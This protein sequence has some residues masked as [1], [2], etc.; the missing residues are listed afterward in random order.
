[1]KNVKLQCIYYSVFLLSVVLLYMIYTRRLNLYDNNNNDIETFVPISDFDDEKKNN[2]S[3]PH[4]TVE[5]GDGEIKVRWIPTFKNVK[6]YLVT[7]REI[8]SPENG[9]KMKISDNPRCTDCSET[10]TNLKNGEPYQISLTIFPK[11]NGK[12]ISG[13]PI[14]V[15]P[16]GPLNNNQISTLLVKDNNTLQRELDNDNFKPSCMLNATSSHSLDR[17]NEP[18]SVFLKY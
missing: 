5:P 13:Q 4:I 15:M 14:T 18:L 12:P 11:T 6:Q 1:M 3:F 8:R 10:I 17:E 7:A 9:M 2:T 16:N